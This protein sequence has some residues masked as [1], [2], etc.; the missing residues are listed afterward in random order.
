[1]VCFSYK[2]QWLIVPFTRGI[3]A[4]WLQR[5][6]WMSNFKGCFERS[7][8]DLMDRLGLWLGTN[9]AITAFA[10]TLQPDGMNQITALVLFWQLWQGRAAQLSQH[11]HRRIHTNAQLVNDCTTQVSAAMVLTCA[12]S[13]I[14]LWQF[15]LNPYKSTRLNAI[16]YQ[17]RESNRSTVERSDLQTIC[18]KCKVPIHRLL[19]VHEK[20]RKFLYLLV[21][22]VLK[23]VQKYVRDC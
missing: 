1:M 11:P 3:A 2:H 6:E 14:Q 4:L 9:K 7:R 16:D 22:T 12:L 20:T 10:C 19:C 18:C 21:T 15:N 8:A 5:L 17:C 13:S 23:S